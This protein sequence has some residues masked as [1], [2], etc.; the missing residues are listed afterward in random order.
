MSHRKKI[1]VIGAGPAG[2]MIAR[3]L[4]AN[5]L[6]VAIFER[7]ECLGG[8]WALQSLTEIPDVRQGLSHIYSPAFPSLRANF[9]KQVMEVWG[10]PYPKGTP[11]YPSRE[12]I[13]NYLEDFARHSSLIEKIR[14]NHQFV[15]L[16]QIDSSSGS[17]KWRALTEPDNGEE[18]SGV[19]LCNSRY[20][21]P[22]LPDIKGLS[23]FT[24][25]VEHSLT[26]RVP[27][28]YRNQR[29]AVMGTGPSGEDISR[30]ISPQ[31]TKVYVCAHKGSREHLV[32]EE[33]YYGEGNNITRHKDIAECRGK[34]LIL[35]DGEKLED[36]D[37]LILCTGYQVEDS[38]ITSLK[39]AFLSGNKLSVAPLY[40]NLFHPEFPELSVTGM[41]I[42]G[43]PFMLFQ[44]QAK[45]IVRQLKG[46]I[47]LPPTKQR[48]YAARRIELMQTG[49][50][51]LETRRDIAIAQ[52]R[53]LARLGDVK[54]PSAEIFLTAQK[55]SIH[56]KKYPNT[57]RDVPWD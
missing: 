4:L 22:S 6:D 43:V 21:T 24:G 38:V 50:I 49:K 41:E 2:L 31:A 48:Q 32:P 44:Y 28:N 19:V 3:E 53:R 55:S 14:F 37:V 11:T 20:S 1:A 46:E 33:G 5:D 51:S 13:C 18:F 8:S 56:R 30:E 35:E 57:Y 54:P 26:Y 39:G 34:T 47:T 12:Q 17:R 29:V 7:R 40:M 10:F 9:P 36:V 52:L 42:L 25:K 45:V 23:D 16:E 15:G 27:E